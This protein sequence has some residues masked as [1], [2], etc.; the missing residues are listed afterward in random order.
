MRL[1][2]L[3]GLVAVLVGGCSLS[4][5]PAVSRD[6]GAARIATCTTTRGAPIADVVGA[7]VLGV[8]PAAAGYGIATER[9]TFGDANREGV[10]T[11][12]GAGI[13]VAGLIVAT[14]YTVSAVQ[15]FR[16]TSRCAALRREAAAH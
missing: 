11:S 16:R 2:L 3:A 9:I 15:G 8:A 14:V 10:Y 4:T 7:L 12:I 5:I 1:V 6:S 13:T